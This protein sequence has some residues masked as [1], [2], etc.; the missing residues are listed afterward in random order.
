[1]IQTLRCSGGIVSGSFWPGRSQYVSVFSPFQTRTESMPNSLRELPEDNSTKGL[2]G[3]GRSIA[4]FRRNSFK[5]FA[6][7]DLQQKLRSGVGDRHVTMVSR[8]LLNTWCAKRLRQRDHC[9]TPAGNFHNGSWLALNRVLRLG[10]LCLREMIWVLYDHERR[11]IVLP[12]NRSS[13]DG[14]SVNLRTSLPGPIS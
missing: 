13:G 14:T 2:C 12:N 10:D 6:R 4:L 3:Q 11:R 7:E 1:M 9:E 5:C 8:E